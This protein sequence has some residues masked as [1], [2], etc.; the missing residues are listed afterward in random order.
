MNQPLNLYVTSNGIDHG[1]MSLE[2]A[3]KRVVSGEFKPDDISWHQGVSGWVPL[4][5]LPEWSQINKTPLPSLTSDKEGFVDKV[6]EKK[7]AK[8]KTEVKKSRVKPKINPDKDTASPSTF[9]ES[10]GGKTGMGIFG[11]LMVT[12]AILVFLSTLGVVVFLIYQNLHK[13]IPT[14]IEPTSE[15][16]KEEPKLIDEPDPFAPVEKN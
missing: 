8:Q 6:E 3:S 7:P 16:M 10:L 15:I 1:P 2:E 13:F 14:T 5:Q 9:D 4:K 12:V 11:K